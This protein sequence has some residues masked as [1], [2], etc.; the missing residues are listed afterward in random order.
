MNIPCASAGDQDTH[1]ETDQCAEE[2]IERI[3]HPDINPRERD[4]RGQRP[5]QRARPRQ[6]ERGD[7][8]ASD[9]GSRVT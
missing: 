4:Q 1:S 2:D 6:H 9:G 7:E 5:E 3:V 8:G